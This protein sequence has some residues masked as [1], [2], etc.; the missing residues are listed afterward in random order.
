MALVLS[1][2][3]TAAVATLAAS[4]AFLAISLMLAPISS[5][6]V[7]TVATFLL[8]CSAAAEATLAWAAVSSAF[9]AICWLT[10]VSSP[11]AL[12]SAWAVWSSEPSIFLTAETSVAYFTTL[13]GWPWESRI[14]KYDP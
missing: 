8:T 10:A 12:A 13:N 2:T 3:L 9:D 11:D 5:A 14:G 6:P 7:A 1:A 4:L